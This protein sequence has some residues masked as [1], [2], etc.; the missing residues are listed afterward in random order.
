MEGGKDG[1]MCISMYLHNMCKHYISQA[2]I[3]PHKGYITCIYYIHI[4]RERERE[5]TRQRERERERKGERE[6]EREREREAS[7]TIWGTLSGGYPCERKTDRRRHTETRGR[8][9]D[10]PTNRPGCRGQ[11]A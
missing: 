10:R 6:I 7:H 4:E 11:N 2:P 8:W 1:Q 3:I 9:K 5:R